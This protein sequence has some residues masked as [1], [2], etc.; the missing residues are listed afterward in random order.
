MARE[1]CD[2][3]WE[4]TF[5]QAKKWTQEKKQNCQIITKEIWFIVKSYHA[6]EQAQIAFFHEF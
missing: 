1:H 4:N 2:Q 6:G 5:F 3:Q